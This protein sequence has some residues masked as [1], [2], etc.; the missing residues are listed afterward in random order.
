MLL[1]NTLASTHAEVNELWPKNR[2]VLK[3]VLELVRGHV[4]G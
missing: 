2:T 3:A 4:V 1:I